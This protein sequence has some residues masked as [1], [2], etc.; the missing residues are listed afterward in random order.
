MSTATKD[1]EFEMVMALSDAELARVRAW[2]R[3]VRAA[4]ERSRFTYTRW[5]LG[6]AVCKRG[7][8][9]N[10]YITPSGYRSCRTCRTRAAN[11]WRKSRRRLRSMRLAA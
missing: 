2:L 4:L 8:R 6:E 9:G 3:T 5:R 7:H 10:V 11:R 1:H